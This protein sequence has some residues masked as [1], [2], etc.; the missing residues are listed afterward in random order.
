MNDYRIRLGM[1]AL[2]ALA[3]T[4][5]AAAGPP[6]P[7]GHQPPVVERNWKCA[8]PGRQERQFLPKD[9]ANARE[10]AAK[11]Q[12]AKENRCPGRRGCE[13]QIFIVRHKLY[14]AARVECRCKRG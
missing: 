5:A 13:K 14:I 4:G 9:M 12:C 7:P 11:I 10:W 3:M 6:Q 2:A 8:C 1:M